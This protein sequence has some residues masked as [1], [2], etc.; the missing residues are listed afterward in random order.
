ML[1]KRQYG[2]LCKAMGDVALLAGWGVQDCLLCTNRWL[3]PDISSLQEMLRKRRYGRLRKAMGDVALLAGSPADANDHFSTAVELSRPAQDWVWC[4]A[5]LEGKAH[6]LVSLQFPTGAVNGASWCLVC[7][8]GR[9]S[10]RR[11]RPLLDGRGAVTVGAGLGV[12][13]CSPRGQGARSGELCGQAVAGS[14]F[15]TQKAVRC[16]AVHLAL[17]LSRPA[18]D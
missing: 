16:K 1:R 2:R 10:S 14:E 13:R 5:A 7:P 4:A 3:T 17:E 8:L 9:Q 6:A 12:V 11:E 18:Q 15:Q